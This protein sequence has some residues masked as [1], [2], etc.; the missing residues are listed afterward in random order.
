M[1]PPKCQKRI[2]KQNK[3]ILCS[4]ARQSLLIATIFHNV[5]LRYLLSVSRTISRTTDLNTT[6]RRNRLNVETCKAYHLRLYRMR[7][8]C[9]E[10]PCAA[11]GQR[12][13]GKISLNFIAHL[14]CNSKAIERLTH[15]NDIIFIIAGLCKAVDIFVMFWDGRCRLQCFKLGV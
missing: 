5:L 7:S 4:S 14:I 9:V 10:C 8:S 12:L 2:Q 6:F 11:M 3:N 1:L 13:Q 15:K